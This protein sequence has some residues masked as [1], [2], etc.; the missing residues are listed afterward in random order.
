MYTDPTLEVEEVSDLNP[1]EVFEQSDEVISEIT[2]QYIE[3]LQKI[4]RNKNKA[5]KELYD[6]MG[7]TSPQLYKK[8]LYKIYKL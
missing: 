5:I 3:F 6:S 4:I 2:E 8:Q 7:D 1:Q